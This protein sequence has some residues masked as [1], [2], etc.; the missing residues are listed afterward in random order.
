LETISGEPSDVNFSKGFSP[1]SEWGLPTVEVFFEMAKIFAD[2]PASPRFASIAAASAVEETLNKVSNW[3][4]VRPMNTAD[5][6]T[7]VLN[8]TAKIASGWNNVSKM[9]IMLATHDKF[10]KMGTPLGLKATINE[11]I[12]QAFGFTTFR[13]EDL[14]QAAQALQDRN[15]VIKTMSEDIHKTLVSLYTAFPEDADKQAEYLSSF[16]SVL[17]G[18]NWGD[19][20]IQ[21]LLEA[22]IDLDNRNQQTMGTSVLMKILEKT[23]A[24][25][26]DALNKARG[27]ILNVHK[28]DP[29]L[30][31]L[32]DLMLGK[33]NP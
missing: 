1:Y 3:F 8:E 7:K 33:G 25:N 11:S 10:T 17:K 19:Q 12:M 26:V 9:Q 23:S 28:D 4:K 29:E 16:V 30:K 24:N 15:A 27:H 31:G 32:F 6:W 2:K 20:D 21:E 14:F 18:D 5:E 13:E 22:V